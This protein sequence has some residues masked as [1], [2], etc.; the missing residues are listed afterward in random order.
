[1]RL[2]IREKAKSI[3]M[4]LL[5]EHSKP[6]KGARTVSQFEFAGFVAATN[7]EY[8]RNEFFSEIQ[9][10]ILPYQAVQSLVTAK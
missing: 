4:V 3:G 8:K 10:P 7:Y 5:S 2:S 9:M 6:A 1:M